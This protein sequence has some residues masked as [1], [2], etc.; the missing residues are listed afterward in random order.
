MMGRKQKLKSGDE[1]DVVTKWRKLIARYGK[2]GQTK[3]VKRRLN[4]RERRHLKNME[5][6]HEYE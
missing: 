2:A 1:W 3:E 6:I 5:H 4:R